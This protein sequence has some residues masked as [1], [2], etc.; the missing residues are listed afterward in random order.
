MKT[1]PIKDITDL[2]EVLNTI[3]KNRKTKSTLM[4][5]RSSRSHA[6]FR[7]VIS[8]PEYETSNFLD[9]VDLAGSERIKKSQLNDK[10]SSLE[11]IS[12]NSSL[13]VLGKCIFSLMH[14]SSNT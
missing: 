11:M 4:N 1:H 14:R 3:F 2:E 10:K 9:I 13:L 5:E 12:I 7:I 8:N 6:I